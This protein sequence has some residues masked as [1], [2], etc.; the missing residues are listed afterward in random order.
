MVR[1]RKPGLS[2]DALSQT[3]ADLLAAIVDLPP[4]DGGEPEEPEDEPE[5]EPEREPEPEQEPDKQP[6]PD[7]SLNAE[8]RADLAA[9]GR[10][11]DVAAG[12]S[13][14][15]RRLTF[16]VRNGLGDLSP[17][18]Y[19]GTPVAGAFWDKQAIELASP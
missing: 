11:L 14:M 8:Q 18:G 13:F 1:S 6:E 10:G 4:L 12:L 7:V 2:G 15:G 3:K 9:R 5:D 16:T 17:R 19:Q